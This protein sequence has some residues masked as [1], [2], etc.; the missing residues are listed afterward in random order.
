MT[1]PCNRPRTISTSDLLDLL[2]L[3]IE[4]EVGVGGNVAGEA[5]GTVAKVAGDVEGGLLAD[6]HLGDTLVPATDDLTDTDL[7]DEVAAADGGVELLALVV[8][9]R[10]VLQEASVLNGDSLALGGGGASAGLVGDNVDAHLG[11]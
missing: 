10:S 9:L 8:G 3:D 4:D 2:Q 6:L 1:N 7:D 5:A 11:C